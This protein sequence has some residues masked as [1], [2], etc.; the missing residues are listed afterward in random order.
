MKQP[1]HS[2]MIYKSDLLTHLKTAAPTMLEEKK[3][4]ENSK[5]LLSSKSSKKILCLSL[6]WKTKQFLTFQ[7][8]P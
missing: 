7:E 8:F 2:L 1:T 5:G 3:N 4:I 6:Y